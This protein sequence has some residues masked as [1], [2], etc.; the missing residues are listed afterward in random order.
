LLLSLA[1]AFVCAAA[2]P[3]PPTIDQWA[4]AGHG[5]SRALYN[6]T[7]STAWTSALKVTGASSCDYPQF[8]TPFSWWTNAAGAILSNSGML[9]IPVECSR[10][11]PSLGIWALDAE[12]GESKGFG[13]LNHTSFDSYARFLPDGTIVAGVDGSSVVL[14]DPT[15]LTEIGSTTGLNQGYGGAQVLAVFKT[16][17]GKTQVTSA[18]GDGGSDWWGA[19]CNFMPSAHGANKLASCQSTADSTVCVGANG[20]TAY[21]NQRFE[22]PVGA[23]RF[24]L[25]FPASPVALNSNYIQ[26][27]WWIRSDVA[28]N[29]YVYDG[30]NLTKFSPRNKVL[31]ESIQEDF[32]GLMLT[33]DESTVVLG[34]ITHVLTLSAATGS[35][36]MEIV[37][38]SDLFDDSSVG[39][40]TVLSPWQN[41][42]PVPLADSR[43][44]I[45]VCETRGPA[46]FASTLDLQTGKATKQISL[47][48]TPAQVIVDNTGNFYSIGQTTTGVPTVQKVMSS[49]F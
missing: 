9:Y 13:S 31:W 39:C 21:N 19:A 47:S 36:S 17:Q 16:V 1:F 3:S 33:D 49:T 2:P 7:S 32:M 48:V 35:V 20:V 30:Y 37:A 42:V 27:P 41:S 10:R 22:N 38:Y 4:L 5:V 29:A 8:S 25:P 45:V 15:T 34:N 26:W 18:G 40:A 23:V 44:M 12:T 28:G 24:S 14:V 43:H 46:Y 11:K 6:G